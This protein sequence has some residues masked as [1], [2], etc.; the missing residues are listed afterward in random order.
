MKTD[1][2]N[3]K[4]HDERFCKATISLVATC[5]NTDY[6]KEVGYL[7]TESKVIKFWC[8]IPIEYISRIGACVENYLRGI[9]NEST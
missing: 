7:D 5:G 8:K 9:S 2:F 4:I 3:V 1:S 6:D